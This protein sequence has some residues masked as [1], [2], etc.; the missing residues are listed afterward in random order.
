MKTDHLSYHHEL[1]VFK[2][3]VLN[4]IYYNVKFVFMPIMQLLRICTPSPH[5]GRRLH[6]TTKSLLYIP[7]TTRVNW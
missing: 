3:N 7:E 2:I 4:C 5:T 1:T 6:S